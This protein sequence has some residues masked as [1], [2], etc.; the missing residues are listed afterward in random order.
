MMSFVAKVREIVEMLGLG[1]P[2][3]WVGMNVAGRVTDAIEA[4]AKAVGAPAP[5]EAI[6]QQCVDAL[7]AIAA[8]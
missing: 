3:L 7:L 6:D 5:P 8:L 4:P 2:S 1:R